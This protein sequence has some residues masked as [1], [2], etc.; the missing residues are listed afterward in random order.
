MKDNDEIM[1]EIS[2]D[3]PVLSDE[4]KERIFNKSEQKLISED[5]TGEQVS[6]VETYKPQIYKYIGIAAAFLLVCGGGTALYMNVR[7]SRSPESFNVIEETTEE[8][9]QEITE[10]IT[11]ISEE[12]INLQEIEDIVLNTIMFDYTLYNP[13]IIDEN[14]ISFNIVNEDGTD[15][16]PDTF[17][18]MN[19]FE[20][21]EDLKDVALGFMTES[22]YGNTVVNY[23]GDKSDISTEEEIKIQEFFGDT[24]YVPST[25]T[26]NGRL[27]TNSQ[28]SESISEFDFDTF[29]VEII[30][31]NSDSMVIK[32]QVEIKYNESTKL[33]DKIVNVTSA[34]SESIEGIVCYCFELV[35]TENGWRVNEGYSEPIDESETEEPITDTTEPT[36]DTTEPTTEITEIPEEITDDIITTE[37]MRFD[38][39]R[40]REIL[41]KQNQICHEIEDNLDENDY[42]QYEIAPDT[43]AK[44]L[45]YT[46]DKYKNIDEIMADFDDIFTD[47]YMRSMSLIPNENSEIDYRVFIEENGNIYE[48]IARTVSFTDF[49]I[50]E[51]YE[52]NLLDD[53]TFEAKY[54]IDDYRTY[55]MNFKNEDGK[56]KL[57]RD[58]Y[59]YSKRAAFF[60]QD[61]TLTSES[62]TFT[63]KNNTDEELSFDMAFTLEKVID[64]AWTVINYDQYFNA[65]AGIIEPYGSSTF[66]ADF[67]NPL[68]AGQYRITKDI[69]GEKYIVEFEMQ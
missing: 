37:D 44:Y 28:R 68:D 46:G 49:A 48:N 42:V 45:R 43:H 39:E 67:V 69:S 47:E 15:F 13:D 63:I 3:Y 20:T 8:T 62:A 11:E 7:P 16:E 14:P 5:I 33:K 29:P 52:M 57:D 23:L 53:G 2:E 54:K 50:N 59:I 65:L 24:F 55:I 35:K 22:C 19:N 25:I 58:Y 9:T 51:P 32:K 64:G 17:Y 30:E 4:E 41:N 6:G 61:D 10:E 18:L 56:Y 36:T 27:Y 40:A 60:L 21:I 26:Y 66:T 31:N 38:Y 1:R 12:D 34:D